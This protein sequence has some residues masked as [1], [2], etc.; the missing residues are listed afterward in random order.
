MSPQMAKGPVR[1]KI[2]RVAILS[3]TCAALV[4]AGGSVRGACRYWLPPAEKQRAEQAIERRD[5]PA[6]AHELE[7]VLSLDWRDAGARMRLAYVYLQM[8]KT[9][10]A[11]D[12]YRAALRIDPHLA[13]AEGA[14]VR[15]K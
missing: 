8:G 6:A 12:Q 2:S 13:E 1:M 15:S 4:I 9:S 5:W 11:R 3:C 7:G 14:L 10:S